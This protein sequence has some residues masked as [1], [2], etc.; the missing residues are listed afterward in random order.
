MLEPT[1][2]TEV[3]PIDLSDVDAGVYFQFRFAASEPQ[4]GLLIPGTL[5]VDLPLVNAEGWVDV[6]VADMPV[7]KMKAEV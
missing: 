7:V 5:R 1:N 2:T 6:I 4:G 3:R